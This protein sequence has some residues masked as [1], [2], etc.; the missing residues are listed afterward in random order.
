MLIIG[1]LNIS[2]QHSWTDKCLSSC[3]TM[4]HIVARFYKKEKIMTQS[5]VYRINVTPKTSKWNLSLIFLSMICFQVE[6]V[7]LLLGLCSRKQNHTV[8]ACC[9][10]FFSFTKLWTPSS[11]DTLPLQLITIKFPLVSCLLFFEAIAHSAPRD[12]NTHL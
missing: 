6:N 8:F 10:Q 11:F 9:L 12:N 5:H 3:L 4:S 1:V 7:R 2:K